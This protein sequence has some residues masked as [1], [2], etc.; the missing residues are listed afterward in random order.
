MTLSSERIE[1]QGSQNAKLAARLDLPSGSPRAFPLFALC[2]TCTKDVYAA[3]RICRELAEQG[4]AVLRFD[5]T[6]LGAS[7]GDFANTNFSSNIEDLVA[8]ALWLQQNHQAPKLLIGHSLGGAAVLAAA[9]RLKEAM[10]VA[11][12][13][14][15]ADPAHVR[16]LFTE[17]Q[18][19]IENSGEAEVL[20]VGRPFRIRKQFLDDIETHKLEN[21]ISNLHKALLVFH[22]PFD[23]TVSIENARHIFT[24]AKHPKSFISL[25]NA[26]HLLTRREDAIYV[27]QILSVWATRYL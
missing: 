19:E 14:A 8:A 13:G 4:I 21:H 25:H 10:A 2:F 22:A 12:I 15:P 16:R 27:A 6:G 1:F 9:G 17:S 20:L 5:F 26:D 7:E 23:A 3:A 18:A 11:T 24:A